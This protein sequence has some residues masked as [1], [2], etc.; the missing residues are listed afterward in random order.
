MNAAPMLMMPLRTTQRGMRWLFMAIMG[1]LLL[2]GLAFEMFW[3]RPH[4]SLVAAVMMGYG[5]FFVGM[6]LL[7]PFLL[8]SIDARQ[9]RMPRIQRSI[10]SGLILYAALWVAVPSLIL[11]VVGGNF[12]A[13]VA[14]QAL[15]LV[16]GLTFGLLPRYF[17]PTFAL[18][19]ILFNLL[20]PQFMLPH[21]GESSFLEL[22]AITALLGVICAWCWWRQM[23]VADPYRQGIGKPMVLQIRNAN[24]IGWND[25]NFWS[26]SFDSS[27][28]IRSQPQWLQAVADLRDTGPTYPERSLRVALGGWLMP[29]TWP[30]VLQ[31]WAIALAIPAF[32]VILLAVT[33]GLPDVAI[34]DMVRSLTFGVWMWCGEY[35]A[36]GLSLV[37]VL[38]LQQRWRRSNAELPL[39]AL[40]PGLGH[41][42]ALIKHLM[43]ATLRRLFCFQFVVFVSLLV[44]GLVKHVDGLSLCIL[45]LGQVAAATFALTFA[46][47]NFGRRPLP[48]WSMTLIAGICFTL[49][50]LDNVCL[51]FFGDSPVAGILPRML[52]AA[53]WLVLLLVLGWLSHRGWRGL[54][55]RPHPFLP[56]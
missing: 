53:G 1:L 31:R 19:P 48:M 26:S 34:A 35:G 13:L 5:E 15:G 49:I 50:G 2:G 46:L 22:W 6:L 55:R 38:I 30:S 51:P 12:A 18:M 39:L 25:W 20:K 42:T 41:G 7:A 14:I 47:A 24:Q 32:F 3:H 28:R 33:R 9:L 8:L 21:P 37:V 16:I 10:V 52:L 27:R 54:Q 4:A 29:R 56:C 11:G 36:I 17:M 43:S 23:H 40:L 45:L 44:I